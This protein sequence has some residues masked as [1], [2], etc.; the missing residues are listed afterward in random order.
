MNEVVN[1]NNDVITQFKDLFLSIIL[2]VY[3]EEKS[4][5]NVIYRIPEALNYEVII[6]DDGSTDKTFQN[7]K[8]IKN[9]KIKILKY[10][11]NQGYGTALLIG[12]KYARGILLLLWIQMGSMIPK[13]FQI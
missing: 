11:K 3:N 12:L 13:K 6:V 7:V 8:K 5:K 10:A 1:Y 4:I 9:P 2:P